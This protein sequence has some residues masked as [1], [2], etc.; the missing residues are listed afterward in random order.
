MD[1][2]KIL[3]E[4]GL[5]FYNKNFEDSNINKRKGI[6]YKIENNKDNKIYIGSTFDTLE[7]RLDYH[8]K[9][10]KKTHPKNNNSKFYTHIRNINADIKMIK[11]YEAN[12]YTKQQLDLYEDYFIYINNT[13]NE[14]LN[15]RYNTKLVSLIFDNKISYENK[16]IQIEKNISEK[17]NRI[18]LYIKYIEENKE[19]INKID[20][21]EDIKLYTNNIIDYDN[22][23]LYNPYILNNKIITIDNNETICNFESAPI[24]DNICGLYV[25]YWKTQNKYIKAYYRG[26]INNLISKRS[27][28]NGELKIVNN[29]I[30][31]GSSFSIYPIIYVGYDTNSHISACQFLDKIKN[32]INS[33]TIKDMIKNRNK[34]VYSIFKNE[35]VYKSMD[36]Y[37][38]NC[39]YDKIIEIAESIRNIE[40]IQSAYKSIEFDKIDSIN[41]TYD[42]IKISKIENNNKKHDNKLDLNLDDNPF[43]GSNIELVDD[44][45]TN[46]LSED[47]NI[48]T[49]VIGR[50]IKYISDEEKRLARLESKRKWREKNKDK[51]N[52]YNKKYTNKNVI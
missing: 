7:N 12:F 21:L 38:K 15:N 14:G 43:I 34:F 33:K 9:T 39:N 51:I 5:H 18:K 44:N 8:I 30:K 31:Y 11:I 52:E 37:C 16:C 36:N 13:I 35:I 24:D 27:I 25:F 50:P 6:I 29:M 28:F 46:N 49:H 20:K 45:E 41:F 26:G 4:L 48:Q 32:Q 47:N 3:F 22:Y 2:I 40:Y 1:P 17:C 10:I 42:E 19:L 23:S